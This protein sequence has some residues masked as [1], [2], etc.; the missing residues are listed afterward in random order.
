MLY[1]DL[2]VSQLMYNLSES[3]L[4]FETFVNDMYNQI[5]KKF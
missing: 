5:V 1:S 2:P 3:N 4:D